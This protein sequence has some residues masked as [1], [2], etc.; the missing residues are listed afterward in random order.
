MD[1]Y[2]QITLERGKHEALAIAI[3]DARKLRR[4]VALT[5]LIAATA[6][7]IELVRRGCKPPSGSSW[8]FEQGWVG[9]LEDM[10][11]SYSAQGPDAVEA[12]RLIA[13]GDVSWRDAEQYIWRAWCLRDL[14]QHGFIPPDPAPSDDYA[15]GW[16]AAC[17]AFRL[18]DEL[19]LLAEVL[20]DAQEAL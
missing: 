15:R 6:A 17:T 20:A 5:R 3:D 2:D 13:T 11:G 4:H 14:L 18:S 10:R 1:Y 9:L 7:A 8:R 19:H 12:V 16:E